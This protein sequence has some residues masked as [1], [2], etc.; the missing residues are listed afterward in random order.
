MQKEK[1]SYLTHVGSYNI[2]IIHRFVPTAQFKGRN[3]GQD[4]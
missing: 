2:A 1:F 3:P 4:W